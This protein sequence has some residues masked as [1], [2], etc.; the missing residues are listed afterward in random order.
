MT[1]IRMTNQ[2]TGEACDII[3]DVTRTHPEWVHIQAGT[4]S[5]SELQ[6]M[7]D[8]LSVADWYAGDK[9]LG[10]DCCGLEMYA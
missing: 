6:S 10:P 5:E 9:H 8:S 4:A 2:Q 7:L 1:T 3:R